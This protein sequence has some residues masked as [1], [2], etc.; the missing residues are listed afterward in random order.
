MNKI[1]ASLGASILLIGASS[2]ASASIL[3]ITSSGVVS[4]GY[5][6]TGEFR[7]AGTFFNGDPYTFV[8]T[9]D[10]SKATFWAYGGFRTDI[11]GGAEY[12]TQSLGGG[13]LTIDGRSL[14]IQGQW[15]SALTAYHDANFN[16]D[17]QVVQDYVSNGGY[18]YGAAVVLQELPSFGF[19]NWPNFTP[20]TG[21]LCLV[22]ACGNNFSISETLNGQTLRAA[23]GSLA[24][25]VI[26]MTLSPGVAPP[27]PPPPPV[28]VP[29][30]ATWALMIGG[31]GLVGS[32][33]RRR[34]AVRVVGE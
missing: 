34:A 11:Y 31:F 5:D 30:P 7:Q 10:L 21:N 24:P 3:T 17:L 2:P 1:I 6:W 22:A 4:G 28:P 13:V 23:G 26:T 20:P 16:D 8:A 27:P 25:S 33:L 15:N 9:L 18:F 14:V 12:G 19:F 32:A 29:E